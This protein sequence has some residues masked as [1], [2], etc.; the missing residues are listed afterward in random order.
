MAALQALATL[1]G[2]AH[3]APARLLP[4]VQPTSVDREFVLR[5]KKSAM[6]PAAVKV[7]GRRPSR[8]LLLLLL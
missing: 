2:S 6:S 4:N 7:F 8:A 5:P 1:S 3:E